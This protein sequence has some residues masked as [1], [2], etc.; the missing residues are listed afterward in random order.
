MKISTYS[1]SDFFVHIGIIALLAL[2]LFLGFFF[3]YLPFTTNHGQTITVPDLANMNL[4]EAEEFLNDHDLRYEVSDCTFVMGIKPLTVFKQYPKAGTKVKEDR[5]IYLTITTVMAPLVRMP[6]LTSLTFKS[7]QLQLKS[8]GLEFGKL[9]YVN[10]LEN[11]A[12]LKQFYNG[13]EMIPGDL[14]PKGSKID[15]VISNGMGNTEMD[16]P[17]VVGMPLDEAMLFLKGSKI[18]VDMT[19]PVDAVE[20]P[21]KVPGT[22]VRQNPEAGVGNKIRVG[23]K[24]DIWVVGGTTP[25]P[26]EQKPDGTNN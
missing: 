7:A 22:I 8:L 3:V 17:N 18:E 9:T 25:L 21:D 19:L 16:V 5:K 4:T 20:Y 6:K 11:N 26:E 10:A 12:V 15:L 24:I 13:K 14:I 23:E 2:S 1:R